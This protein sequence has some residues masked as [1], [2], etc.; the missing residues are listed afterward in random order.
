MTQTNERGLARS[1]LMIILEATLEYFVHICVTTTC[2]TAILDEMEVATSLQGVIGA[3][4]SLACSVQLISVFFVKK[5]YPCKRWVCM[6]NLVNLLLFA[7]LYMIPML[8]VAKT[9]RLVLFIGML[10]AAYACQHFL[11]PSRVNW[12]MS[13]VDDN[14][15]GR[16]TAH[17]EIVSLVGGMLFSQGS[18]ILLDH[19]KAKGD[20]QTC[21]IIFCI[22]IVVLSLLHLLVMLL[23]KEPEPEVVQ[24]PK[25]LG[26]ICR[27]VFGNVNLRRVVIF[28]VLFIVSTVSLHFY[29]IYLVRTFELSYTY[30]TAI[31]IL[32]AA[33]RASVS[34]F[35]GRLADKKS[36]AYMLRVCM[37]VLA[38]GFA[39]FA[40]CSKETVRYLYPV[41]SLCYAFSLGGTNAGKTNLCLDY[42]A[43]EDRRYIL[44]IQSAVSGICGFFVT[45]LVS[46][47]VEHVEKNGNVLFG[48]SVYPQQILFVFSAVMLLGL[49]FFYMPLFKKPQRMDE[50]EST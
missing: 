27:L 38:V 40:C 9:L 30:I 41:F 37:T 13:L 8:Q 45:L 26:E 18:G 33:F 5:T 49:A 3:I 11:T 50:G 42:A 12:Q 24:K 35:L 31:S 47:L 39:V 16:F 19:Y 17:K 46:F 32:H 44:G 34:H 43:R 4:T 14:R 29:S 21:F 20:M 22:A 15:R 10:L 6:L 36:W 28:D 7:V 23:T 25:A 48:I 2:L 1:R